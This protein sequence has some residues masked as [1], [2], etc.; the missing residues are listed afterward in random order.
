MVEDNFAKAVAGAIAESRR[1]WQD[2]RSELTSRY[3]E[4]EGARMS[5]ALTHDDPMNDCRESRRVW[6]LVG[7]LALGVTVPMIVILLFRARRRSRP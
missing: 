6:V 3:G 1:Q 2:F 7:V 5:C 4:Q